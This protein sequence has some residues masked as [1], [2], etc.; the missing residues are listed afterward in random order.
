[1]FVRQREYT[2]S[3]EHSLIKAG[4]VVGQTKNPLSV[5]DL[6]NQ[7]ETPAFN[8]LFLFAVF[9]SRV[10]RKSL[11]EITALENRLPLP[12]SLLQQEKSK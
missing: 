2:K 9:R 10:K 11:Y 12:L 8:G 3:G 5:D 4:G 1:M 7:T 6:R